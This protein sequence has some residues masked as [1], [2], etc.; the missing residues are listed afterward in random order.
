[1]FGR[2]DL[3]VVQGLVSPGGR[4]GAAYRVTFTVRDSNQLILV[5]QSW[6]QWIPASL[7]TLKGGSTV[8]HITFAA[9]PGR[10]TVEM[11]VKDS[12][13]GRVTS[14]TTGITAY[15][16]SPAAS[17]LLLASAM[18]SASGADTMVGAGEVRK[19]STILAAS[20]GEVLTPRRAN[21][22]C[23]LEL[24]TVRPESVQVSL[25]VV[26]ED[27]VHV[28]TL[29]PRSLSLGSAGGVLQETLDLSGLPP[30]RYRLEATVT[31]G[32]STVTR[33]A[34]F[35][36]AGFE[37]DSAAASFAANRI[38]APFDTMTEAQ[39]DDAYAPLFYLMRSDEQGI[40]SGLNVDGKRAFLQR[41]WAQREAG[42]GSERMSAFYARIDQ[43]NRRFREGGASEVPG[44][45]TDRGR[46]FIRYGEP[47]E[48]LHRPQ[49]GSTDPYEVWKY[50]T[51][52]ALKFV[53]MDLTR[54][55]NYSLIYTNDRHETSRPDWESLLGTEA[56]A[57][58]T[59]F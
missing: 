58:V 59:Q 40:Y 38:R 22:G 30:G 31:G 54:F 48:V 39:L 27:T 29:P 50:S 57:D 37:A 20:G 47:D 53:F 32:D 51:G 13:T 33:S 23:Y 28:V 44:W 12:A 55:G 24:Y 15:S 26:G 41:F 2:V 52:R 10:Y 7:L 56:L 9:Q 6:S 21:L 49:P 5:S 17:D 25:R 36:M 45:R 42:P 4:P 8:E 14:A 35:R 34:P 19:G 46:I 1:M 3:Q 16:G 11:T 43:A 18:R